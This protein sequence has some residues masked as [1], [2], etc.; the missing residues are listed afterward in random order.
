MNWEVAAPGYKKGDFKISTENGVLS[1]SAETSSEKNEDKDNYTRREF[2]C[3]SSTRTFTLPENVHE[4]HINAKYQDGLLSIEL[5][6][7]EKSAAN[8]KEVKID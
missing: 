6:K 4:D 2:S 3:S 7:E 5:K 1:I 8:K